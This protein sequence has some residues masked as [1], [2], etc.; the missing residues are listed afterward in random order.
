MEQGILKNVDLALISPL[1]K[2]AGQG[3]V[4]I[5]GQAMNYIVTPTTLSEGA[6][7]SVPVT[8]TGPW[9]NLKFRPDLDKLFNLLLDKKLKDSEEAKKLK[10]KLEAAKAK[11]K[12]PEDELK[13]KLQKELENK[14]KADEA[15]SFEDQAK[16]KL[17]NE[18]GN[19]LKKLFD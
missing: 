8:I 6:E 19:A 12:N 18:I 3:S 10:E 16:E 9:Q 15:K 2:A 1:F 11:L 13:K 14:A 17:E 5:G 4:D 7:F